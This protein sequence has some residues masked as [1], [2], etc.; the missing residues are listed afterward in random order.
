MAFNVFGCFTKESY[1]NVNLG[2]RCTDH[3]EKMTF[4]Y[5]NNFIVRAFLY[6]K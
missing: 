5:C 2:Q 1:R 6:L 4:W 3:H